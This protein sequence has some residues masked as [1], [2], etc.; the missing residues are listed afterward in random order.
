MADGLRDTVAFVTGASSG[1]GDATALVLAS[2]GAAVAVV[3][4]RRE[5]LDAL[6]DKIVAGGGRALAIQADVGDAAQASDA[7]AKTVA[8]FGRAR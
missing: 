2:E 5:R 3:A 7:L 6:V 1:I 8:E 4:R